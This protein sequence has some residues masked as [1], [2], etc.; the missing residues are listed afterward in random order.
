MVDIKILYDQMS[1][2]L[3]IGIDI[4]I[5]A[6]EATQFLVYYANVSH[7]KWAQSPLAATAVR[8]PNSIIELLQ[9]QDLW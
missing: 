6:S 1:G 7:H 3:S 9:A 4:G 5:S 8:V 2:F